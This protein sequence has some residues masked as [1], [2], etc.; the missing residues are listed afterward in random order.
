MFQEMGKKL[1][2]ICKVFFENF[3]SLINKR[4]S[5]IANELHWDEGIWMKWTEIQIKGEKNSK[6][7]FL[8]L[9][10]SLLFCF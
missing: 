2:Y 3:D 6:Y 8:L 7:V 1:I 4:L 10:K 9:R 5:S